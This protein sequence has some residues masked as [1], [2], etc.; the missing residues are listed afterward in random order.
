MRKQRHIE[1]DRLF[2]LMIRTVS[3]NIAELREN[4]I[5]DWY[6]KCAYEEGP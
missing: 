3:E 2:L 1:L 4:F 6:D 5:I